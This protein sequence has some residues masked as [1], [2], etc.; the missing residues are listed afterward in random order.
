MIYKE[1]CPHYLEIDITE[2]TVFCHSLATLLGKTIDD[3]KITHNRSPDTV[4][5]KLGERDLLSVLLPLNLDFLIETH[6]NSKIEE[7][8][9]AFDQAE[10]KKH[11]HRGGG[12]GVLVSVGRRT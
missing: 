10:K 3:S 5:K 1:G 11:H 2:V 8:N 4:A 7:F 12:G 9:E 6:S